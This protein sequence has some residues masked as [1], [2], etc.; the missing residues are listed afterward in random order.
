MDKNIA[1]LLRRDTKTVYVTYDKDEVVELASVEAD[2]RLAVV[3]G[4]ISQS[5]AQRELNAVR[6]PNAR[7]VH[8]RGVK[9]K[10]HTYVTHLDVEAGDPIVVTAAGEVKIAYVVAGDKEVKIE[11][12]STR[13]YSWVI[14][15]I[16]MKAYEA[17]MARNAQIEMAVAEF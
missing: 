5:E 12:N 14:S 6:V 1:A 15:K 17:N 4:E 7:S 13:E 8:L 2:Y 11:P 3:R 16:D 10:T 9:G